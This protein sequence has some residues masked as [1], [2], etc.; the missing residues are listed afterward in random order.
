MRTTYCTP[1]NG[2][3]GTNIRRPAF[4]VSHPVRTGTGAG[5]QGGA[6]TNASGLPPLRVHPLNYN[7]PNGNEQ[8]VLNPNYGGTANFNNTGIC[9]TLGASCTP[10]ATAISVTT[11]A[12]RLDPADTPEINYNEAI[13]RK[14]PFCQVNPE[15]I[16]LDAPFNTAFDSENLTACGSDPGEPGA[17][18]LAHNNT[19]P[20]LCSTELLGPGSIAGYN[21]EDNLG[22]P[23]T[24][25]SRTPWYSVPAVPAGSLALAMLR[26]ITARSITGVTTGAAV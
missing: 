26:Q 6:L 15:P 8:R 18:S 14:L 25:Q 24:G 4:G 16:P 5:G 20:L 19:N 3:Y 1:T 23:F 10:T 17:A 7:A 9:Y 13:G 12:S 21:C 22:L 11:G 2:V